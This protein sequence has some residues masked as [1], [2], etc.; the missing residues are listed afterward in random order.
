MKKKSTRKGVASSSQGMLSDDVQLRQLA[1]EAAEMGCWNWD[2][3]TG[4]VTFDAPM[5][6]LFGLGASTTSLDI[7]IA[8]KSIH[9]DDEMLLRQK[10]EEARDHASSYHHEFRLCLSDSEIRWLGTRGQFVCEKGSKPDRAI[11]VCFNITPRKLAEEELWKSEKIN[12]AVLDAAMDA[13]ITINQKG[14]IVGAN[15]ATEELFGYSKGEIEGQNVKILIPSPDRECYDE[16]IRRYHLTGNKKVIGS[17]LEVLARRKDGSSFPADL[18]VSEVEHLGFFTGIISDIS[19]RKAAEKSLRSEH[20]FNDKIVQTAQTAIL[21]LDT[22]G[23]IVRFNPYFEKISGWRLD[24]VEGCEWFTT[25]LPSENSNRAR[26][27]F[28]RALAGK[29]MRGK[30]SSLLTKQGHERLVEWRSSPLVDE[31]GTIIGLLRT[32]NDVTRRVKLEQEVIRATEEERRN[33]A[34][35][36]H[37]GLGS[38]LTGIDYRIKALSNECVA[39]NFPQAEEVT[40]ISKLVR[41]AIK[42]TRGIARGLH[43]TGSKPEDLMNALQSLISEAHAI[44]D[45]QLRFHCQS[46]VLINDPPTVNHLYRIAQEAFNNAIK[47]S[48]ANYITISLAQK[49]GRTILKIMDD[50]AGFDFEGPDTGN[51]G[52]KTMH[53]RARKINASLIINRRRKSGTEVICSVAVTK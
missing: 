6:E 16:Y 27:I 4:L 12:K 37:D 20:E 41:N 25:F 1:F 10:T 46:P 44:S 2:L 50:G 31:R 5:A 22:K 11:G 29:P 17:K 21:I 18:S 19:D 48:K 3:N 45:V 24:E 14:I 33:T 53:Y 34:Q 32:G 26:G 47:H 43:P 51:L 35:D 52:L 13:I 23:R 7:E 39:Q 30:I 36:L 42:Q 8:F 15:S 38:L 28:K 40:I 49:K 9:P